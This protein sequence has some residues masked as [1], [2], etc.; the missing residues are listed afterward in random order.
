MS[1]YQ[2]KRKPDIS[3]LVEAV[4]SG[5]SATLSH[6]HFPFKCFVCTILE[7]FQSLPSLIYINVKLSIKACN[8]SRVEL[9]C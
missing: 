2:P 5:N 8:Y 1:S 6:L 4:R 3:M 7:L 9:K